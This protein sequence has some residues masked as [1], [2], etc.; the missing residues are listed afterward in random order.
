MSIHSMKNYMAGQKPWGVKAHT[1]SPSLIAE[2]QAILIAEYQA[3][4]G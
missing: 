3:I 4:N 1:G 2:Y